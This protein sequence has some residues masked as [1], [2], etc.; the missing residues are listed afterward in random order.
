MAELGLSC[1]SDMPTFWRAIAKKAAPDGKYIC[2]CPDWGL[3]ERCP[4]YGIRTR[5]AYRRP[6]APPPVG[7][8]RHPTAMLRGATEPWGSE[9]QLGVHGGALG[10]GAGSVQARGL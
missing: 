8:A 9:L 1:S 7:Q 3:I 5:R 2:G 4:R 6:N 10:L